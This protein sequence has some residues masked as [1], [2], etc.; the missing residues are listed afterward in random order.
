MKDRSKEN[1]L[2][3]FS[4]GDRSK[5]LPEELKN[6]PEALR[7]YFDLIRVKTLLSSLDPKD[8]PIPQKVSAIS[9]QKKTGAFLLAA[10]SL[11]IV[12]GTFLYYQMREDSY[13]IVLNKKASQGI[14]EQ[15]QIGN[16]IQLQTQENSTC[17]L[18]LNG[19]GEFS[20]RAFPKTRFTVKSDSQT[21]KIEVREGSILFSSVSKREGSVVEV[22]SPHIRSV[23]LGTSLLV[24]ANPDKEKIVLI[25]GRIEVQ[26]LNSLNA[27]EKP[28]AVEPG[29]IA[30]ATNIGEA[31]DPS[32]TY[33]ISINKMSPKEESALQS[34]LDSVRRIREGN[35]PKE[36]DKADL[37][38]IENIRNSESWSSRP[39]VQITTNDGKI[40]E[41]YLTEIGD[42]YSI[43]TIDSG[44]I[45]IPK[46]SIV[47]MSTL[48]Q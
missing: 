31:N 47:E 35:S 14:C 5:E 29:F 8:F 21:L 46:S 3:L 15:I 7:E 12:F 17:D 42:F 28:I 39:Y 20:I 2:H 22:N 37:D 10:A 9:W 24:S 33:R 30:E 4:D 25:E 43:Y 16:E 48:R 40:K 18:G 19:Q 1:L 41:G 44:L 23:L 34:Q 6:D 11:L 26:I 45:R 36:Y 27:S 32:Q 13:K 38:S